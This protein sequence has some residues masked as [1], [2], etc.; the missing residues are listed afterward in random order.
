M[1]ELM[2]NNLDQMKDLDSIATYRDEVQRNLQ[3]AIALKEKIEN[4]MHEISKDI[5]KLRLRKMELEQVLD[6]HNLNCKTLTIEAD[7]AKQKYFNL[8]MQ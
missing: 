3:I 2:I 6:K 7:R 4:E 5:L 8:K 1:G